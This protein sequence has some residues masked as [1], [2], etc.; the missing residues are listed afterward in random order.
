MLWYWSSKLAWA[1]DPSGVLQ[2]TISSALLTR[3]RWKERNSVFFGQA[4]VRIPQCDGPPLSPWA[5]I[6]AGRMRRAPHC[7]SDVP[8]S[9]LPIFKHALY[10]RDA[11][12]SLTGSYCREAVPRKDDAPSA[13]A[14]IRLDACMSLNSCSRSARSSSSTF[15]PN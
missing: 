14:R 9:E 10:W 7:C 8:R 13:T 3:F 1:Y 2:W 15:T 5:A 12:P 4:P 11:L 6:H